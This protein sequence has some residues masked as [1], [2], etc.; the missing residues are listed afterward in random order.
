MD[1]KN[2]MNK[3]EG[4]E[5]KRTEEIPETA[6][7]R[8]T[9]PIKAD[10]KTQKTMK[11]IKIAYGVAVV[12]AIAAAFT[13]KTATEKAL[14]SFSLSDTQYVITQ[15]PET[16]SKDSLFLTEEIKKDTEAPEDFEVRQNV[17]DVPDT[18]DNVTEEVADTTEKE[19]TEA[20]TQKSK[21]AVPYEDYYVLPM[22]M[23]ILKDYSSDTPSYNATMGDWRTHNGVDFKGVEGDQVKAIA[24]GTVIS[25]YE[26]TLYGTV[27][28]IDHGNS[29]TAKYCGFNPDT[30]EV[31]KGATVDAGDLLGY[32]GTVPCEKTDLSH[33]HFEI[34]YNGK[35]VDPLEL[36]NK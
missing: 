9:E 29:V 8:K 35:N 18:R 28:E 11:K 17:T 16:T 2:N 24:Y 7:E 25:V 26:D 27:I 14:G 12:L 22:G 20:T 32:L 19:E 23:D 34:I 1:N 5:E 10:L 33:L 36:M 21:N 6:P 15:S 4:S 13:A 31:K 30:V 3:P